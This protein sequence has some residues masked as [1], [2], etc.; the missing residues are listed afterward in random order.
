[1][2]NSILAE[3]NQIN[4]DGVDFVSLV[5]PIDSEIH[6]SYTKE[7]FKDVQG[8][9]K[10]NRAYWRIINGKKNYYCGENES[11]YV[12]WKELKDMRKEMEG[13]EKWTSVG[14]LINLK[15]ENM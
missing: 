13:D 1:M 2:R 14:H 10:T 11:G 4:A 12:I 15:T 5:F 6:E 3:M 9:L 7:E 8:I